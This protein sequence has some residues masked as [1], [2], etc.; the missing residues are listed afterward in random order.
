MQ[1][2][3]LSLPPDDKRRRVL[4]WTQRCLFIAGSLLLAV[5]AFARIDGWVF[6]HTELQKLDQLR[7]QFA[8]GTPADEIRLPAG[9][10][11]IDFSLWSQQRIHAFTES[12]ELEK[13]PA[14][15]VLELGRLR[16]RVPVFEGTDDLALNRGAGWIKGTAKPGETGNTA[17]AAHRDG[18][19]RALKDVQLGDRVELQ[20]QDKTMVYRVSHKEIINPEEIRVL[21]PQAE[22]TLTLVTCYPFYYVGSAP[23][24]FIV[25]ALLQ[26]TKLTKHSNSNGQI[27]VIPA[28]QT[29][30]VTEN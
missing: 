11:Q 20:M 12:V 30:A 5:Y 17:I 28:N 3:D 4:S 8:E 9:K 24:R 10:D 1:N 14:L 6:S 21:L 19:F 15:A 27:E 16:I 25:Q 23:Q 13:A 26:E 2:P 29:T 18:F 7:A 22:P